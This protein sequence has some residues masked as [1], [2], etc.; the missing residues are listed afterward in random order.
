[1]N[2]MKTIQEKQIEEEIK[3]LS[4]NNS[5]IPTTI[6]KIKRNDYYITVTISPTLLSSSP[7]PIKQEVYFL[8][9]IDQTYPFNPPK[10][11]CLTSFSYPSISDGRD[12]FEEVINEPWSNQYL[13]VEIINS[14]PKFILD[15]MNNLEKKKL[16]LCGQYY[17]DGKYDYEI[18]SKLPVYFQKVQERYTINGNK[19][20]QESRYLMISDIFFVLFDYE[21]LNKNNLKLIFWSN[22]KSLVGMREFVETDTCE[23]TWR[24]KKDRTYSMKI[25]TTEGDRIINLLIDNLK[26]FGIEYSITTKTLGPK[27]GVIPP[28]DIDIVE[29]QIREMEAKIVHEDTAEMV[30]FLMVLYEKAVQYYSAINN[31]RYEIFTKKI[32]DMMAESKYR[33]VFDKKEEDKKTED[34]KDSIIKEE[35]S[36]KES[37]KE[38]NSQKVEIPKED[39][40]IKEEKVE[41]KEDEAK[42]DND[43]TENKIDDI[44]KKLEEII[45]AD[46][47]SEIKKSIEN[48]EDKENINEETNKEINEEKL[49]E[50]KEEKIEEKKEEIKNEKKEEI[51]NLTEDKKEETTSF[52]K[53]LLENI[54]QNENSKDSSEKPEE[55]VLSNTKEESDKEPSTQQSEGNL[56]TTVKVSVKKEDLDLDFDDE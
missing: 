10:L 29:S 35:E 43:N 45:K 16:Q 53:P 4:K 12:L 44:P 51:N 49:E 8:L 33:D 48:N 20:V 27:E 2:K 19:E 3:S 18:I 13:L 50:S 15:F 14:I 9:H 24:I 7:R 6:K 5:L 46:D 37:K 30:K 28:I 42:N 52:T 41:N 32:K 1:M 40:K 55:K 39:Q 26:K 54:I 22:I 21:F 31:E 47:L 38:E 25:D 11:Y 17:L 34:K 36:K 56:S 23:F